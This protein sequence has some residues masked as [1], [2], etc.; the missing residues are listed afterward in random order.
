M[1]FTTYLQRPMSLIVGIQIIIL[2]ATNSQQTD[3]RNSLYR[4]FGVQTQNF[5]NL[6]D[7][8]QCQQLYMDTNKKK[9]M[10]N[11]APDNFTVVTSAIINPHAIHTK[12][13]QSTS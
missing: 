8:P 4:N 2:Y 13:M 3:S 1:C 9:I 12:K 6:R 5:A 7:S 10:K 11:Q